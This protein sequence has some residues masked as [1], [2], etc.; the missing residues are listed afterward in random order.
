[1]RGNGKY[2]AAVNRNDIHLSQTLD[3]IPLD[4]P[5]TRSNYDAYLDEYIRAFPD[6]RHGIATATRLLALKR[7]DQFVCFDKM[8]SDRL[9]DDFG[10]KRSGMTYDRYWDEIV[11]RINDTPWWNSPPPTHSLELSA[12]KGR[13]AML[14]AIF[15]AP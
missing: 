4:D 10:I 15:Y 3:L 14:D 13:A 5:I 12:W 11:E 8:N 1:M 9:C 7:P 2:Y 6:G